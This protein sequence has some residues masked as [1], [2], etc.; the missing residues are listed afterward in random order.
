MRLSPSRRFLAARRRP[1]ECPRGQREIKR[2]RGSL[3]IPATVEPAPSRRPVVLIEVCA[4]GPK[5]KKMMM[6]P[7]N[8]PH[9]LSTGQINI[10]HF[11]QLP[12]FFLCAELPGNPTTSP[13]RAFGLDPPPPH[14][15]LRAREPVTSRRAAVTDDLA[16]LGPVGGG[17]SSV[18]VD[19]VR[20]SLSPACAHKKNMMRSME[21]RLFWFCAPGV[22]E[23]RSV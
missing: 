9:G 18:S 7:G 20:L 5:G 15:P 2:E 6:L 16:G 1:G 11:E 14:P 13:S 12:H 4:L 23:R 8:D 21:T 3:C 17:G 10:W 22:S 19:L